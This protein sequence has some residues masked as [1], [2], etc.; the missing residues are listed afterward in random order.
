[1][2]GKMQLVKL[3]SRDESS[4]HCPV[5]MLLCLGCAGHHV[6]SATRLI[7]DL[8]RSWILMLLQHVDTSNTKSLS[9]YSNIEKYLGVVLLGCSAV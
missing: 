9:Y 5:F 3:L 8:S 1:M 6:I 7:F 2:V 4:D